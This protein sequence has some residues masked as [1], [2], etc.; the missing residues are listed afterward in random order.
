MKKTKHIFFLVTALL[1]LLQIGCT[2]YPILQE[3]DVQKF[4]QTVY[5]SALRDSLQDGKPDCW[6]AIF[7]S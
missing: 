4:N 2:Q 5:S 6:N 3:P 7:C 1:V